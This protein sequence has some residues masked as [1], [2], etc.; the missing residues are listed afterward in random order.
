M[1]FDD[2]G[3]TRLPALEDQGIGGIT[4]DCISCRIGDAASAYATGVVSCV[5]NRAMALGV[6]VGMTAQKTVHI[7]CG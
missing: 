2:W 7:L 6:R 1:G 4:L 5:N 3:V